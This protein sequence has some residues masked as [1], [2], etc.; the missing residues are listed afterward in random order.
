[1]K[2]DPQPT[3]PGFTTP[4]P[5]LTATERF[6]AFH[7]ANPWVARELER[8]ADE[9]VAAGAARFGVKLLI[10]RLRWDWT[11]A[12]KGDKWRLNNNHTSRYARLLIER[13]PDFADRI[14]TRDLRTR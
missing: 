1:M 8:L 6:E 3:L 4:E 13:R 9:L 7:R 11:K 14:E 2:T 10:E 12:T 5:A